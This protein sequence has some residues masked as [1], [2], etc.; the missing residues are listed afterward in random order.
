MFEDMDTSVRIKAVLKMLTSP[1]NFFLL[2]ERTLCARKI[3]FSY[4]SPSKFLKF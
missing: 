1:L 4:K 3:I 2:A